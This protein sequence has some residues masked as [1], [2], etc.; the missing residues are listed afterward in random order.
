MDSKRLPSV[1]TE[2]LRSFTTLSRTLN[3]S[4]AVEELGSTRQTVRRHINDLEEEF[5][6][7]LLVLENRQYRLTPQGE[8]ALAGAEQLLDQ[9]R[10]W[11][12]RAEHFPK[13]CASTTLDID[14]ER[15]LYNQE[16]PVNSIWGGGHDLLQRGVVAWSKARA[17]LEDPVL[18]RFRP[19]S[20]VYRP[21]KDDWLCVEVGSKSSYAEWFDDS[22]S[23]SQIGRQLVND[24]KQPGVYDYLVR[25][26]RYAI[27]RGG[28]YYDHVGA[29]MPQSLDGPPVPVTYQRL[30][31]GC[32]FPN[33]EPAV[34]IVVARTNNVSIPLLDPSR[35]NVLKASQETQ[36]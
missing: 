7:K 9:S 6:E 8:Q 2:M 20:M 19:F 18:A 24:S 14:T 30:V 17:Q 21:Y 35:L 11:L 31:A 22:I 36:H 1:F 26:Y 4:K 33:G 32:F 13:D 12:A 15:W 10:S 29:S 27:D 3:L 16:H 25:A 34:L 28:L 23:K 5:G